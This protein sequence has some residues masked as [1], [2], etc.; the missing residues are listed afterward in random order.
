MTRT[1]SYYKTQ[2]RD[3]SALISGWK[4]QV[5]ETQIEY[6]ENMLSA[7]EIDHLYN[8]HEGLPTHEF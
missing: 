3:V 4:G 5:N 6:I 8:I 1:I 7:F 2:A